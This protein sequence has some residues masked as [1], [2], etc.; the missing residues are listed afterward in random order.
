MR[1]ERGSCPVH[2]SLVEKF[3]NEHTEEKGYDVGRKTG[4]PSASVRGL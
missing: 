3:S 1:K 2:K 4:Q